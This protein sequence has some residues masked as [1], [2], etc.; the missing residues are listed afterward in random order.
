VRRA[1]SPLWAARAAYGAWA[2]LVF[3]PAAIYEVFVR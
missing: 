1:R 3:L 2:V